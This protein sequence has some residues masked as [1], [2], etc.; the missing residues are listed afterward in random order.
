MSHR[1]QTA[2]LAR[3]EP[4]AYSTFRFVRRSLDA[5][6]NVS[7]RY[8]LDDGHEFEER[9]R[10]PRPTPHGEDGAAIDG[11]LGLLHWVAG[12][13]YYKAAAPP[14][15]S[16]ESGA[17]PPATAAL[18][19]ALYSDGLAEFALVNGLPDLPRP[20][21]SVDRSL[22]VME[23]ASNEHENESEEQPARRPPPR[24][25]LVPVGDPT[26]FSIGDAPPIAGTIG[27]AAL[28]S[29]RATRRLDP[30]LLDCNAAGALNGHVPVTAIVSCI[31]LLVAALNDLDAVA[32]A[33]E[34]SASSPN[35]S[36]RGIEV[37]H[38][39][40]KGELAERLLSAAAGEVPGA[41]AIFSI[42]RPASEL[43]IARAFVRM[44][45]YHAVFTSCNRVFRIDPERR[46]SSWCC[47]CDKCRFVFLVLA[48][49]MS[50]DALVRIFGGRDL[51][52]EPEQYDG[53]AS[54]AAIGAHKPFECVGEARESA[55]A[56]A[57]LAGNPSWCDHPVVGRLAVEVLP[58]FSGGDADLEPILALDGPHHVPPELIGAVHA[59]LGP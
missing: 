1:S 42:L 22:S 7:L 53:F 43:A 12:V 59:V 26:L 9:I 48:P 40:S 17:P 28:P 14:Q 20:R 23:V 30:H 41:P 8:A 58:R 46:A 25:L 5:A 37:N 32:M 15:V 4:A 36:H 55:A 49:F 34:Q 18:L 10:V 51:L 13:S 16:F 38:Q 19:E 11:L 2:T 6:G 31:A 35:A 39:F 54:L 27:V 29:L 52:A 50:P 44:P 45:Q 56:I 33:N 21:F 47:E 24:R 3:F 57:M